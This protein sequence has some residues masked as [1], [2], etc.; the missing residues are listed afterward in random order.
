[1]RRKAF[2]L[3]VVIALVFSISPRIIAADVDAVSAANTLHE[4]GLFSGTGSHSDGTPI[5]ELDRT[6]SRNEA[7]TMLVRLLGKEAIAK[8]QT[9]DMP[10]IDVADWAKPYI[11]YAYTNGLTSGTSA[12]TYNGN[13]SVTAT[14]YIT[15]VLRALGYI[16][17]TDFQW[18]KAWELSD[19]IGLTFGEYN[20]GSAFT[21]GD[22][23][24]ISLN[25]LSAQKKSST[26]YIIDDMIENGIIDCHIAVSHHLLDTPQYKNIAL[27]KI[28]DVYCGNSDGSPFLSN[29]YVQGNLVFAGD[30]TISGGLYSES[31]FENEIIHGSAWELQNIIR[32]GLMEMCT[33]EDTQNPFIKH[34]ATMEPYISI[35]DFPGG[36][37][38][39]IWY[40]PTSSYTPTWIEINGTKIYNLNSNGEQFQM[41]N[42]IRYYNGCPCVNDI[43][44]IVGI[45]KH[46]AIGQYNGLT[47][48]E[49]K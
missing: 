41:Q 23:A 15:F 12:T 34:I 45:D 47:Y 14:Q 28:G 4:L 24:I 38:E 16:S 37:D 6:P 20:Y 9:W 42:G 49:M 8:S 10:F 7:V 35:V 39:T 11:G 21:R 33:T 17:G 44:R 3:L 30:V 2:S 26:N 18:D 25:A 32:F 19:N 5:Y 31:D 27:W 40:S 1:M 48:I 46:I 36:K 13:E 29:Y 43:F 22:I